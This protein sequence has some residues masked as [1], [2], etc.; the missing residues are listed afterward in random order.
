LKPSSANWFNASK[1]SVFGLAMLG[2]YVLVG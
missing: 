1:G 2:I